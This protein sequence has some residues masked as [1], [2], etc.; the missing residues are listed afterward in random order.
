MGWSVS[1]IMVTAAAQ[2]NYMFYCLLGRWCNM[3]CMFVER[4]LSK[5]CRSKSKGVIRCPSAPYSYSTGG[6]NVLFLGKKN[7]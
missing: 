1:Y 3:L 6:Y 5:I 7:P 2:W 4:T